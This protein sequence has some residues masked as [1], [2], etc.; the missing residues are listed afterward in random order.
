MITA[1]ER[2]K[3]RICL[4][5]LSLLQTFYATGLCVM[6][7]TIVCIYIVPV[8]SVLVEFTVLNCQKLAI[9]LGADCK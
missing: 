1:P 7:S 6:R 3:N 4:I 2:E 9:L 8:A 5:D